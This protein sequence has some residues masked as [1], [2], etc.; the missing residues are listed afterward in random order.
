MRLVSRDRNYQEISVPA[1]RVPIRVEVVALMRLATPL[2]LTYSFMAS[3][4]IVSL[5]Y[6]GLL[7]ETD[8]LAGVALASSLFNVIGY[9]FGY[10]MVGPLDTF[11]SQT[12][13]AIERDA[14]GT[15]KLNAS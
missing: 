8:A 4:N 13:G 15:G 10:G 12:V 5:H 11:V 2:I 6:V 1:D 14:D 3:I 9:S 7:G